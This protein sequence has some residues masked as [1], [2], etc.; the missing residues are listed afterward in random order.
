MTAGDSSSHVTAVAISCDGRFLAYSTAHHVRLLELVPE[1]GP[2]P[3]A[4]AVRQH[5][6]PKS[7]PAARHI[8]LAYS[9]RGAASPQQ[10][11][12]ML[13]TTAD[14]SFIVY[15]VETGVV[16]HSFPAFA[17]ASGS[18]GARTPTPRM[19]QA[20]EQAAPAVS[21]VALSLSSRWVALASRRQVRWALQC[22]T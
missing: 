7:I 20:V 21:A 18:A 6:V 5:T 14:G 12:K 1:Q 19:R 17:S 2:T 15:N 3:R 22:L 16:Q 11:L 8:A 10:E 4:L 13:I 9:A